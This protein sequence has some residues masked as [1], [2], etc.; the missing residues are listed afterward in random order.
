MKKYVL[1]R[2]AMMIPILIG[3]SFIVFTIMSFTPGDPARLILG[4]SAPQES[5]NK[6]HHEMGLDDPFAVRYFRYMKDAVQGDFGTSYRTSRPVFE[7]IFARFPITLKLSLVSIVLVV[8][9]GIPLGIL[10][11]IKQYSILDMICTVS[12]M[13]MAS[14]PGFWLGLMM[15]LLFSLKLGWLP[16]NGVGTPAHYIMP[17]IAL[18]LPIA[19]EVLRM[20]RSAMLETIR[21][22]YIRTA[23][24]KGATEKIVIWRHAL[25]NALLPIVTVIGSEFGGLLGGTIL[26]ESVFAIP[27]LG[28]LV[29]NSIRTK[30]VPQVMAATMFIALIFCVVLLLVDILYAFIDP[31]IKARYEQVK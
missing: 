25:K 30:D 14:V 8:V 1:K 16:S 28:S 19:A 29:V 9:I 13:L 10:S 5:V 22:D 18:S 26:I 20:T 3:V 4:Q 15:I 23:R 6:L 17:A 31:R 27:G 12:A 7:E 11:A 21:Q 2:I 24:S